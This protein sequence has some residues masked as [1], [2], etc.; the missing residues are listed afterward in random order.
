MT[1][2]PAYPSTAQLS[3]EA[4]AERLVAA[5]H[6]INR[7]AGWIVAQAVA[8]LAALPLRDAPCLAPAGD[9]AD[10]LSAL[11][12]CVPDLRRSGDLD[13]WARERVEDGR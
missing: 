3:A 4:R 13:R 7:Q 6:E 10:V 12:D 1:P 11:D 9:W 2:H 5:A 8:R